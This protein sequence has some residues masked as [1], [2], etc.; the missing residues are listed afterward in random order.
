MTLQV[1]NK[2][3][4]TLILRLASGDNNR[5]EDYKE[6]ESSLSSLDGITKAKINYSTNMIRIK[7][8]PERL[9]FEEIRRALEKA[10]NQ[11]ARARTEP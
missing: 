2:R 9:T 6:V 5:V 11:A 10:Q 3:S 7:F 8:D 4:G 1:M